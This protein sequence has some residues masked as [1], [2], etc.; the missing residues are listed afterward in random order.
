MKLSGNR[1]G[2]KTASHNSKLKNQV[3]TSVQGSLGQSC[4]FTRV[5]SIPSIPALPIPLS[6]PEL[7]EQLIKPKGPGGAHDPSL[8][9]QD[10]KVALATGIGSGMVM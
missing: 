9:N 10:T 8:A 7:L 1:L 6:R 4:W 3:E 5:A 2:Q